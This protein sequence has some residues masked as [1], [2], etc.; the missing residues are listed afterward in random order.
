MTHYRLTGFVVSPTLHT[1]SSHQENGPDT[2]APDPW[3]APRKDCEA[4]R[5]MP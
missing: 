2:E 4:A 3:L 1:R 5:E